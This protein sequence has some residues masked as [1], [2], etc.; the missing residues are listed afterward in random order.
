MKIQ[1]TVTLN[2]DGAILAVEKMTPEIQQLVALFD[3]WRQRAA[4]FESDLLMAKSALT[5]LQ[6]QLYN[7]IVK[8]REEALKRAEAFAVEAPE[9]T[10]SVEE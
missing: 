9:P 5:G 8:E 4:D 2:V 3:D 10:S 7:S 1:P 6:T